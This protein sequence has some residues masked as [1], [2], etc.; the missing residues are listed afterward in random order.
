MAA[1]DLL[2]PDFIGC[3][4]TNNYTLATCCQV[5]GSLPAFVNGTFGC[6]FPDQRRFRTCANGYATATSACSDFPTETYGAGS[7][8]NSQSAATSPRRTIP[9]KVMVFGGALT[10]ALAL[11]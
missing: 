8:A 3:V 11:L 4:S 2:P 7:S 6:P 9:W 5:G 10:L 1:S